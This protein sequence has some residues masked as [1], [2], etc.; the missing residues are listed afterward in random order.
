M[1]LSYFC[2]T[3]LARY[4]FVSLIFPLLLL[5]GVPSSRAQEQDE[6]IRTETNLVQLNVGVVDPQGRAI[7]SLSQG[8][9]TVYEDGV[10]QRILHFDPVRRTDRHIARISALRAD[11]L[12]AEFAGML[13]YE[14][15]VVV[16]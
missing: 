9:F 14:R 6:V 16:L 15:A 10:K 3:G 4:F 12:E 1:K 5:C 11:S 7:T 13:K 2:Q 8:E